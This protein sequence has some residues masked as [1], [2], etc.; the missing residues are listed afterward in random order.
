MP[1]CARPTALSNVR[2]T[3]GSA[4]SA[5]VM[6]IMEA[7]ST[8]QGT[9]NAPDR[10]MRS[11]I[12]PV[13]GR[14]MNRWARPSIPASIA[15]RVA[16]TVSACATVSTPCRCASATPAFNVAWSRNGQTAVAFD[17]T[18]VDHEFDV[19][20]TRRDELRD[21]GD[22][23]L[24]C[25]G[26]RHEGTR[27]F[28]GRGR[29]AAVAGALGLVAGGR[30]AAGAESLREQVAGVP[31]GRGDAEP[32]RADV[33]DGVVLGDVRAVAPDVGALHLQLGRDTE[34]QRQRGCPLPE[35]PCASNSPGSTV[36]PRPSTT[37]AP[38]GTAPPTA[39]MREPF[40][41]AFGYR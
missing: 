39:T 40:W 17:G 19:V 28:G 36:P 35:W 26:Q 34:P 6:P 2:L 20:R 15:I 3:R 8:T 24:G 23:L 10:A 30:S 31:A 7:F 25:G 11:T 9:T 33:G 27:A 13:C 22:H 21:E 5:P 18:V 37:C 12:S 32:G 1:Q 29:V 38:A 16:S 41:H 14:S 4:S